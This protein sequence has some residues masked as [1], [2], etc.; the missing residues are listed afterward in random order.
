MRFVV[1][2]FV[3]LCL[4]VSCKKDKPGKNSICFIR[5]TTHLKIENN[6]DKVLYTASFGQNI[7]PLILWAP[8]CGNKGIQPHSSIE[9][10]LSSI[11]GYSG[12]DK[13]VVYWWEC[14]GDKPQTETMHNVILDID[15]TECQ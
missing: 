8:G 15:E 14:I 2:V 3:V 7:L 13:L 12:N 1:I 4:T 5:T 6:T 10:E 9:Q 11:T